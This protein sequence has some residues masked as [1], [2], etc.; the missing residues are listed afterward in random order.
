MQIGIFPT[1][2]SPFATPD[3]LTAVGVGAEERGFDSLWVP[4]HVVLFEEYESRYPYSPDGRIPTAPE[5]GMLDPFAALAFLASCTS[6]IRLATGIALLPQRN[7]VYAAKEIA[8]IDWLSEGRVDLGI[9]VGWL[10]EEF[11]AVGVD[12]A[13]RGRRTDEYLGVLRALWCDDPS[14]YEGEFYSLPACNMFPKPVQ[15][16]H[17]PV[18]IGGESDAA[19]RRVARLGQGWYTIDRAPDGLAEP[20][21]RLE[22]LLAEQGRTRDE[23]QVTVS[24]YFQGLTPDM[25]RGYA[26]AG[27][28]RVTALFW[29][30]SPD[31]VPAALDDLVPCLEA[32]RES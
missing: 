9:G 3:W 7:P 6:T 29:A 18:H 27:V 14:S 23:V 13:N 8:T 20:L 15:Q 22:E 32:A 28:D 21:A 16:P 2:A 10:R 26:E 4:E 24:P 5:S 12:W 30:A 31:D 11:E 1:T 19:L 17:P 25:V